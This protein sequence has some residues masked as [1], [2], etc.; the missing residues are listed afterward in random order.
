MIVID[1]ASGE[2]GGQVVRTALTLSL[3]TGRPFR[4]EQIRAR[5]ARPGLLRQHLAAVR[6]A[7]VLGN[8]R[9]DGAEL[10]AARLTFE[11]QGLAA[12]DHRIDIGSAGSVTLVAQTLIPALLTASGSSRIAIVGGTHNP[13][14][15]PYEFLERVFVPLLRRM[16]CRVDVALIRPGYFPRGGGEMTVSITPVK[17]LQPL[18]LLT[19]GDL[20]S[21][22]TEVRLAHLPRGIAER[23]IR[24]VAAVL[25]GL[26]L[27]ARVIDDSASAGPGNVVLVTLAF[28]NVTELFAGFGEKRVPAET[29]A[30]E[31]ADAAARFLAADAAVGVH[32]ADQLLLPL[33]LCG[34]G[35]F[36]TLR[37]SG[38]TATNAALIERFLPVQFRID[39]AAH[40]VWRI[41]VGASA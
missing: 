40:G 14:A 20:V 35:C 22:T 13:L 21:A 7:Q 28:R 38:H 24:T 18:T 8:A 39:A 6:A 11:P 1:G 16:G 23:E 17:T 4:I 34:A 41:A 37:P 2:G 27:H 29:V 15:P 30:R 9:V 31:A 5:R 36:T 33:A 19:R 25:G 32:L 10:G 26:D 12:G 3:L